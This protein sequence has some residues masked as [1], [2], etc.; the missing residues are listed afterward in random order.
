MITRDISSIS[1]DMLKFD[2]LKQGLEIV[3]PSHFVYFVTVC[4]PGFDVI[5]FEINLIFLIKHD[6]KVKIKI[7]RTNRDFKVK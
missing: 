4:F 3:S 1:R 5:N 6:Q 2:F 7:F